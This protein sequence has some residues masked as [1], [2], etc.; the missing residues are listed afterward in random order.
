TGDQFFL[1]PGGDPLQGVDK[2]RAAHV[3][4]RARAGDFSLLA[5]YNY[6]KKGV[7]T[8]AFDTFAPGTST[9][10]R[11]GFVEADFSRTA[12]SGLGLDARASYDGQRYRGDWQ[13]TQSDPGYDTSTEDWLDG[14][15]RVRLPDFAGNRVFL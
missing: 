5:S 7:P 12:A 4:L 3:D 14:E 8:G 6:R 15:L 1:P 13:Y 11:R 2:E 10:D 9:T